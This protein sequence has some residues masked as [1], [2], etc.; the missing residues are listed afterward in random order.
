M[1]EFQ[2]NDEK[3]L[4]NAIKRQPEVDLLNPSSRPFVP[5]D[6]VGGE[7]EVTSSIDDTVSDMSFGTANGIPGFSEN[8]T[9]GD[10]AT[11]T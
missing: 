9:L 4:F 8:L 7:K 10:G 6:A 5:N 1:H 2:K 11:S 3:N